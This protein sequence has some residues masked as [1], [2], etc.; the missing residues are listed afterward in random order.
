MAEMAIKLPGS[1]IQVKTFSKKS[2]KD[3]QTFFFFFGRIFFIVCYAFF[4]KSTQ[5]YLLA[6]KSIKPFYFRIFK[7][8][9]IL[10]K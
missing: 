2:F 1:L 5:G 9:G 10:F 8:V 7:D 4:C 3:L 6:S